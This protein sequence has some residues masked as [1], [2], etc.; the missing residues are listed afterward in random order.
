MAAQRVAWWG[1]AKVVS[2]VEK[3]VQ[4][5]VVLTVDKRVALK[6]K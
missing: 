3:L 5:K 4:E 6:V 2:S 1:I